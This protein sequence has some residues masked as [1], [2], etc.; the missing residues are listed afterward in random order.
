MIIAGGA[1]FGN[2]ENRSAPIAFC[3]EPFSFY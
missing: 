1:G 2:S 3:E